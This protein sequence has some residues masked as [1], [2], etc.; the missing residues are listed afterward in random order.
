MDILWL[1]S[2]EWI[3][4]LASVVVLSSFLM[5][6][7][8]KLRIINMS[9]AVLFLIYGILIHSWP[10]ITTNT[11]IFFIHVYHLLKLKGKPTPV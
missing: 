5:K 6:N 8:L 4:H 11:V 9:G 7:M 3:G 10:I 2:T 1:S